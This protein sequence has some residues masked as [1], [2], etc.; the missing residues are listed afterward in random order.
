M[1]SETKTLIGK[2]NI[3]PEEISVAFGRTLVGL[4][5]LSDTLNEDKYFE[6]P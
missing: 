5:L 2:T 4:D 6:F 3:A 1:A